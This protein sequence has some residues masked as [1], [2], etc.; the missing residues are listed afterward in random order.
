MSSS[1]RTVVCTLP[2]KELTTVPCRLHSRFG[3]ESLNFA[4]NCVK[5]FKELTLRVIKR[6]LEYPLTGTYTEMTS[7]A[8]RPGQNSV[9]GI[10][11]YDV[12][13]IECT[14]IFLVYRHVKVH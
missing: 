12:D 7:A 2:K 14:S 10:R 5:R 1:L 13:Q 8:P 11:R 6:T 3:C 4:K 9:S